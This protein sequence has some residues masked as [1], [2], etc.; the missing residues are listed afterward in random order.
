[1]NKNKCR[2]HVVQI[3]KFLVVVFL[4]TVIHEPALWRYYCTNQPCDATVVPSHTTRPNNLSIKHIT[5]PLRLWHLAI[6]RRANDLQPLFHSFRP[7]DESQRPL[8]GRADGARTER[9][10]QASATCSFGRRFH[11]VTNYQPRRYV[12]DVQDEISVCPVLN[13]FIYTMST[14]N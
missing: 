8:S 11:N 3:H 14:L 7:Y 1:M 12:R 9:H 6:S 5:Q 13:L 4:K 10:L 2:M